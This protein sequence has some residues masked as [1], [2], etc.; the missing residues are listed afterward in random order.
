MG[1]K[2][3]RRAVG[4]R[5]PAT[6]FVA[7]TAMFGVAVPY[8]V[9]AFAV[10]ALAVPA[11]ADTALA[12]PALTPAAA[13]LI[14]TANASLAAGDLDA[15]A[16]A[17]RRV[18]L[19]YP[20]AP[21]AAEALLLSA[22]VAEARNNAYQERFFLTETRRAVRRLV[23]DG[24]LS[25][26]VAN[27]YHL[28]TTSRLA[29]L[30]EA[31]RDYA[32]ALR[33]YEEA[34]AL[35]AARLDSRADSAAAPSPAQRL[36]RLRLAAAHLA[37]RH[38]VGVGG[39]AERH[40]DQV[41]LAELDA[42]AVPRYR[43]LARGLMWE[44]LTP[45]QL[46]MGDG[47]ISAIATDGDDVWV[48]TWTGG[49]V[50]HT[51]STGRRQVFREG[52]ESLLSRRVRDIHPAG[53]YVWVGTDEGLSV[54][55][56]SSGRWR[57]EPVLGGEE[58]SPVVAIVDAGGVE[59][60]GTLGQG[61]W[62][63]D[64]SGWSRVGHQSLPGLFINALQVVD[65]TLWI[66]TI[67]LGLV[68]LDLRSGTLRSF[69]EVNPALGPQNVTAI[70]AEDDATLWIGTFGDG[71]YR[72]EAD[73]NRITHF[74]AG[75]GQI[76]DDWIL[77]AAVGD[78]GLY[79]GTFGGGAVRHDPQRETWTAISLEQGLTSLNVAVVAAAR[80]RIYFGTLGAGVA[81]LSEARSL[82]GL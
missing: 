58:P 57:Q 45:R 2:P 21:L 24:L 32:G 35:L 38:G 44:H 69:D 61:L 80:G 11:Y 1:A 70:V 46:G 47:N 12:N 15:A 36:A 66:G 75:T 3:R 17:L 40:F 50:R 37:Y 62:R 5:L 16:A 27:D 65:Q 72:W 33:N 22:T 23:D 20:D 41:D 63:H 73:R 53:G 81:I 49:L 26:T 28:Q 7:W 78:A 82:H 13:E 18:R 60:A 64:A 42:G 74:S 79:F 56:R 55:A 4:W 30:L 54:Y 68:S 52:P 31:E 43:E 76:P 34:I 67:D 29:E 8:A 25:G 59:Y 10:L 14:E 39:D 9:P 19:H 6:T 48:G 51:R 71:L 77:A